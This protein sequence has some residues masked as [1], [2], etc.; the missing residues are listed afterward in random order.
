MNAKNNLLVTIK[1]MSLN[2]PEVIFISF[3]FI[4]ERFMAVLPKNEGVRL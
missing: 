1:K 3:L 4:I 2:K